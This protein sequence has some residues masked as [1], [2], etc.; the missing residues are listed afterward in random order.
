M[1]TI[2][3]RGT[4]SVV[5]SA[6]A[7]VLRGIIVA[8][9]NL[10]PAFARPI[11]D[12]RHGGPARSGDSLGTT[13]ATRV[14]GTGRHGPTELAYLEHARNTADPTY[15][16]QA[17]RVRWPPLLAAQ[18]LR[19]HDALAARVGGGWGAGWGGWE[20]RH[21]TPARSFSRA[22]PGATRWPPSRS[23]AYHAE[24]YSVSRRRTDAR[25]GPTLPP[26]RSSAFL[27]LRPGLSGYA[28]A[29]YDT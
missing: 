1:K 15:Y 20:A 17:P 24:S 10:S 16:S 29:S 14:P 4:H 6:A 8:V 12:R 7:T 23:N 2:A 22:D 18:A 13:A 9:A 25:G 21:P 26:P 28:R 5:W 27:D 3:V 11:T 19:Q